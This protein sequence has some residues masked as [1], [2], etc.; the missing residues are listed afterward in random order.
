MIS[1]SDT[2]SL[3]YLELADSVKLTANKLQESA[4]PPP[5]FLDYRRCHPGFS[6]GC[7]KSKLRSSFLYS[8][9]VVIKL[10][11]QALKLLFYAPSIFSGHQELKISASFIFPSLELTLDPACS[12]L[13]L[14]LVSPCPS[15]QNGN[16]L[17]FRTVHRREASDYIY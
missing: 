17:P 2:G 11:S 4:W 6:H 12:H 3:T 7:W 1:I 10:S 9:H 5:P 13:P 8:K 14:F 16:S 15:S